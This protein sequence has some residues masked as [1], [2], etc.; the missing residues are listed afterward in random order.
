MA[1]DDYNSSNN[2]DRGY[3]NMNHLRRD[4]HNVHTDFQLAKLLSTLAALGAANALALS[5]LLYIKQE[6]LK[7]QRIGLWKWLSS[8]HSKHHCGPMAIRR[9]T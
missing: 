3:G 2:H 4:V 6:K 7:V 1:T 8:G 9:F 5:G